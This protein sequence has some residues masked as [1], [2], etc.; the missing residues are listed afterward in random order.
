[1]VTCISNLDV[2]QDFG[3]KISK[4]KCQ[5]IPNGYDEA[6]FQSIY[7]K[8]RRTS[9][10]VLMHLGSIGVERNPSV[11]FRVIAQL[12]QEGVINETNFEI[13]FVG[14][15]N[16]E[17]HETI[18][19]LKI[20]NL[21]TFKVYIPHKEALKTAETATVLLLL[22]TQSAK[23][24]RILPGKTFE[25]MRMRKPILALGPEE[26]EVQTIF[27]S[28]NAGKVIDYNDASQIESYLR[29]LL[30]TW[31]SKASFQTAS[32]TK[33]KQ[34]SRKNLTRELA[35]LFIKISHE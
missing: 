11:M 17:I 10:F 26:G 28:T 13:V 18:K 33:V 23:N 4:E 2:E 30:H 29:F 15:V 27:E 35:K 22:I 6:D 21:L 5:V 32:E 19:N 8:N 9:K 1:E 12:Y 31:K 7:F 3:K 20:E 16:K 24:Q 14:K 25:Y 34:Y